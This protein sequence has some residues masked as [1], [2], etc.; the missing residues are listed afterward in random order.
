MT[1]YKDESIFMLLKVHPETLRKIAQVRKRKGL[2][3]EVRR[4]RIRSVFY[5]NKKTG[6]T[7]I[8]TRETKI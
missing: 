2:N 6:Q 5:H 8:E 7:I 4:G 1:L 3:T